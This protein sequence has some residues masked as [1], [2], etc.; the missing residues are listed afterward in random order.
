M[1]IKN[2]HTELTR[3]QTLLVINAIAAEINKGRGTFLSP[4]DVYNLAR[5]AHNL[6]IKLNTAE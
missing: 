4:D 2:I 6:D 3:E 1:S 5:V